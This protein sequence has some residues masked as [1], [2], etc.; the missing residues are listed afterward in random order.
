MSAK[1]GRAREFDPTSEDW[2]S[3]AEQ[4]KHYLFA[5]DVKE[6]K[7]VPVLLSTCGTATYSLIKSLCSPDSPDSKSFEDIVKLVQDHY[8]PHHSVIMERLRFNSRIRKSGESISVFMADLRRIAA[9]CAFE[10]RLE[11]ML[12][13]RLVCGV[14]DTQIQR[15]LLA[16]PRL[17]L[18]TALGL[19]QAIEAAAKDSSDVQRVTQTQAIPSHINVLRHSR[20]PKPHPTVSDQTCQRCGGSH[21]PVTCRFKTFTCRYCHKKGHL[22]KVCRSKKAA[23]QSH[24]PRPQRDTNFVSENLASGTETPTPPVEDCPT[25]SLFTLGSRNNKPWMVDL[26]VNGKQVSMQIDTGA[27]VSVIN[28]E[29][30]TS[31]WS[32]P[33]PPLVINE[34]R[35]KLRT[36]TGEEIQVLGS[37]SPTIS[38]KGQQKVLPLLVV[39]GDGPAL[40]GRDGLSQL[41]LDW[42]EINFVHSG[43][44]KI[45]FLL[46]KFATLFSPDLGTIHGT[47]IDIPLKPN[48]QP[49]FFKARPVPY[50]LRTKVEK[51]LDRLLSEGVLEPVQFSK[52]AAP[53]VPVVKRDGSI[54]ICGDYKQTVN[55]ASLVDPY[56][57]PRIDDLFTSLSGG[58]K[59]SK[60]DLSKAYQQLVLAESSRE[61]TT[62]NTHKG[63]YRYTRLPFGI[64][65]APAIFQRTMDSLLQGLNHVVVYLDDIVVTGSS[66]EEHIHNLGEVLSR[67]SNA[68]IHLKRE[69]C[70]FFAD[71]VEYLGHLID[72]E[73]LHPTDAKVE[74]VQKAPAPSNVSELKS[75][76]GL[77]NYYSKFLPN[78]SSVL[79]PLYSLL[80][81]DKIWTWGHEEEESFTAAKALLSSS[82]LLVHYDPNK[83]LMLS[84]DASSYGVGAVLSHQMQDG[85]EKPIGFASRTMSATE[86]KYSQLDKEA[87]ALM[88]GIS[89]F[90]QYLYGRKFTLYTDHRPLSHLFHPCRSVPQM[91]SSRLQRWALVLS[92]YQYDIRYKTGKDHGNADAFS[93]LPLNEFPPNVPIPGDVVLVMDHLDT[94]PVNARSIKSWTDKDPVLSTVR[95]YILHGWPISVPEENLIPFSRRRNELSVQDGCILWG[96]RVVI[97]PPGRDLI[98]TELHQTHPGISRMKSLARGYVWWPCMDSDLEA[99]VKSC[100]TCQSSRHNPP[101]AP[102]HPWHWPEQPWSRIHVDYAGPFLG[103]TFLIIIDAH[104]KWLD[105]HMTNSS[106]SLATIE[107]LR[108]SFA[109]FGIPKV[110][111]TDNGTSFT[112]KEFQM[113]VTQNGISHLRSAP[114]HPATNGLAERAVQTFKEGMRKMS[115]PLETRLA[116]FLFHYRITPQT[117]TG[118]SPAQMLFGRPLRSRL[119][120]VFPDVGTRIQKEPDPGRV[121]TFLVSDRVWCRDFTRGKWIPGEISKTTGPLSYEVQLENGN[122]VRRHVDQLFRRTTEQ[123]SSSQPSDIVNPSLLPSSVPRRSHRIRK[124]PDWFVPT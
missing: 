74:A 65:S 49:K 112:S 100:T 8:K 106:S 15:R 117:S 60:L 48:A 35:P 110:I 98:L 105:V 40:L 94:T 23:R 32:S 28:F 101:S 31:L 59:F 54:R 89:K 118:V 61:L 21:S 53:I 85:S 52:W 58:K 109:T 42:K 76:L 51:E 39:K 113:F 50:M 88:F 29:T 87:L 45:Q 66:D 62:I 69:K 1:F 77:L 24:N 97:P 9:N 30:Y 104:S 7:K 68:G 70:S 3:Y 41:Q 13:D 26:L 38:Y 92:S 37:F 63:L 55:Q 124:S 46:T 99:V 79:S 81:A 84:C 56:P 11:E 2:E 36:Y 12:R 115:G 27:S 71:Q 123:Q 43:P 4:M 83:P 96:S 25:Y 72:K 103:K 114:Y 73:G 93:R 19:A 47:K 20:G 119:D 86:K 107:K 78:L 75:F 108:S 33:P 80:Q 90:H 67:L 122:V 14:N 102:V 116:K 82:K 16:E 17:T 91:A 6:A 121:R 10:D 18:D 57:L 22:E 44:S 120:L 95:R 64:S 111:V 34:P 5:N